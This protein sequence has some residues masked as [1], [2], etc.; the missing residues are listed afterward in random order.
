MIVISDS[1]QRLMQEVVASF[2]RTPIRLAAVHSSASLDVLL[3]QLLED[4]ILSVPVKRRRQGKRGKNSARNFHRREA[5]AFAR[6]YLATK[7]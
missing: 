3:D 2:N 4:G 7:K 6:A 1:L 5:L